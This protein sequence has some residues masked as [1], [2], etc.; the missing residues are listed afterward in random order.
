MVFGGVIARVLLATLF[1]YFLQVESW[2]L[3]PGSFVDARFRSSAKHFPGI[4]VNAWPDGQHYMVEFDDGDRAS[5]VPRAHI[6]SQVVFPA[7]TEVSAVTRIAALCR[8]VM[9]RRAASAIKL[10]LEIARQLRE[11]A[12]RKEEQETEARACAVTAL[13]SLARGRSTRKEIAREHASARIA[14]RVARFFGNNS[15]EDASK[16]AIDFT[17]DD[18]LS[19]LVGSNVEARYRGRYEWF[20]AIISAATTSVVGADELPSSAAVTMDLVYADGDTEHGVPRFR[21]RMPGQIEPCKLEA[22]ALVDGRYDS[23]SLKLYPGV[24]VNAWPDGQN[25]MVE[26]DDGDKLPKVFASDLAI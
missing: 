12:Q 13:Q 19:F 20:K 11:E 1:I 4:V 17:N 25:Y 2:R 21:V 23:K 10:D 8:G 18:D 15:G 9:A 14:A 5:K 6:L 7:P 22:G 26:F 24:V 3:A 16:E